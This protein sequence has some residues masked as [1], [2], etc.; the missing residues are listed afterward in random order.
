MDTDISFKDVLYTVERVRE[1]G[2]T[3][4]TSCR[5]RNRRLIARC[6]LD[7]KRKGVKFT[8]M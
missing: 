1:G 3:L 6:S 5:G 4:V 8:R 7:F 2:S